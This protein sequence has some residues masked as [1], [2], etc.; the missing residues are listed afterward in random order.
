MRSDD[1]GKHYSELATRDAA[2]QIR[3][4]TLPKTVD[5]VT[6][7]LPKDFV[8]PQGMS[9]YKIDMTAPEMAMFKEIAVRR[10]LDATTR[11]EL[12][13]ALAAKDVREHQAYE[14]ARIAD[15]AKLGA[16]ATQ[17][18]TSLQTF[19]R[20]ILG[21]KHANALNAGMYGSAIVE[22]FE[23]L[24][25]KFSSQGAAPFSQAHRE[26]IT[27]PGKVS[28]EQ[29]QAMSFAERLDYVRSHNKTAH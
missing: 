20:G 1:F 25:T 16:T 15:L 5:E 11:S 9:E 19:F 2:E 23:D 14:A 21:E 17:R 3:R 7:D 13:G 8:L 24:A 27:A 26:P 4:Q 28:E 6:L 10:G 12:L 22:A 18:I 29:Y